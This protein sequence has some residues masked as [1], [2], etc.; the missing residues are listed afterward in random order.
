MSTAQ[1]YFVKA[2]CSNLIAMTRF[3][4]PRL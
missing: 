2:M 4:G 3:P 1:C